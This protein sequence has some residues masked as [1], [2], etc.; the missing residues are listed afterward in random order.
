MRKL[1]ALFISFYQSKLSPLKGFSCAHRGLHGGD[2]CSEYTKQQIL[3]QGVFASF[4]PIKQRFDECRDAAEIIHK[5]PPLS[6]RGD[7]DCGLSGCDVTG[8]DFGSCDFGGSGG[9]SGG[10]GSSSSSSGCSFVDCGSCDMSRKNF[11]R[12]M[13]IVLFFAILAAIL[14]YYIYG[15]QIESVNIRLNNG[16]E[17][18][19]DSGALSK[20]FRSQQPDYKVKFFLEDGV[21]DTN[22]LRNDS[23][24]EWLNLSTRSSFY[25][26][27]IKKIV[28]VNQGITNSKALETIPYP[29]KSGK[30]ELFEY[31]IKQ[32]WE[33]F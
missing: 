19:V 27:D 26:S 17:E 4:S 12:L 13:A 3:K 1:L 5:R 8:L 6:Q 23:A 18:T 29:K 9:S 24:K 2:S 14:S 32:K 15:K 21:A 22:T 31:S 25:L 11:V 30:G 20:I 28:I 33:L 7:C 16:I 10:G